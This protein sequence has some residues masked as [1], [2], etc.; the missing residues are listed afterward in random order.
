MMKLRSISQPAYG[1]RGGLAM[2]GSL[3]YVDGNKHLW[4]RCDKPATTSS[5]EYEAMWQEF[6][7]KVEGLFE[8]ES[9]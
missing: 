7:G 6:V 4:V 1:K 5:D 2:M 8:K 3:H 9:R